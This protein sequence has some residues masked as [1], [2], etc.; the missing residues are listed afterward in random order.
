[1]QKIQTVIFMNHPLVFIAF[2]CIIGKSTFI[3]FILDSWKEFVQKNF[4]IPRIVF[5]SLFCDAY[6]VVINILY[7]DIFNKNAEFFFLMFD[8]LYKQIQK[9]WLSTLFNLSEETILYS[10]KE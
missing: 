7:N 8:I 10:E 4:K 1:M 5:I 6:F 2:Y 9:K 3:N